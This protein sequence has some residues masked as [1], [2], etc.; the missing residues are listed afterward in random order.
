MIIAQNI[1]DVLADDEKFPTE[2]DKQRAR[3]DYLSAVLA[4]VLN[5]YKPQGGATMVDVVE[6]ARHGTVAI[7]AVDKSTALIVWGSSESDR[8]SA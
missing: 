4:A 5:A 8:E 1:D 6:A 7:D 3:A 2:L